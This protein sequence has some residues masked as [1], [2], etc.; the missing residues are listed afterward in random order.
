[1]QLTFNSSVNNLL[2]FCSCNVRIHSW[3]SSQLCL[4][5]SLFLLS[6]SEYNRAINFYQS[7]ELTSERWLFSSCVSRSNQNLDCWFL[8]KVKN[9]RSQWK[10]LGSKD[11]KQQQTLSTCLQCDARFGNWTW[12]CGKQSYRRGFGGDQCYTVLIHD[13]I[14]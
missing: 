4:T 3:C 13:C 6:K 10:T 12:A 5:F 11:K 14:D 8:R 1:M 7:D 2:N 9:S